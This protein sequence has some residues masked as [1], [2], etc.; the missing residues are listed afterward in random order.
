MAAE[1]T[2]LMQQ[3]REVK[4]RHPDA[5]VF[6]R[7]G[8]FYEL[9][10]EDAEEGARLLG[11][12]L[13]SRNN[14][15]SRAPLAGVPAQALDT[16][17]Q[18][19]VK[20]GRRVSICDQVEDPALAKGIIRREVTQTVTPGAV[21]ADALLDARRNNFLVALAGSPE[22]DALVG[23][24]ISDLSTGEL[25]LLA[26]S[27]DALAEQLLQV[28]PS[29]LLLPRGWELLPPLYTGAAIRTYRS[30]WLFEPQTGAE[31]MKRAFG[32]LNLLGFGLQRED[33]ARVGA[34][35]ALLAYLAEIQ[36]SARNII[37]P[38]RLIGTGGA[39]AL[40]EMTRRNLELVEPLRGAGVEGTLLHVLDEAATPM[41]ARLLR[42]WLQ[43]PLLE[44]GEIHARQDAVAELDSDP[45]T[46]GALRAACGEIRDLERLGVKAAAGRA[47][48]REL[49]ALRLSLDRVPAVLLALDGV[50]AARLRD[51]RSGIDPMADLRTLLD[52][53]LD[54]E[55]PAVLA[56]GG[57]IRSGYDAELDE[58]RA[59]RD[60][61][62]DWIAQLQVRERERSGIASLKVGF[63][64]VFGYY[65][66]VTRS[67]L[68]RVPDDYM[69]KQTLSNAERYV[70]P[71]LKVWEERV[72]G[73]EEKIAAL[74]LQ[75]FAALRQQV[76]AE[77][78]RIH[79]LAERLAEVD[80]LAALAEVAGRRGYVR[81]EVHDGFGLEILGGRHP[82]VELMMAREEFIPNDVRLDGAARVM[83]LTGPNMAG[84]STV[85]RQVGLIVLMAQIG[86]FVP[87]RAASI[88]L[89]DRIFTRVGASDHLARGQSTF[90]VE[91]NETAAILHG[92]NARS[93][94]LLD[95]IGRG[96]S[97]WDGL[98]V[99]TA[100]TEHLHEETGSKTIFAT[101]Y[102]ELTQLAERLDGVVNFSVAVREDA[103]Q[104]VF[105]RRLVA[106]GAD[107]SYGVEVARLAGLP[108]PVIGRARQLLHELEQG[109][110]VTAAPAA[111]AAASAQL[112]LFEPPPHPALERL[113]AL[114]IDDLTPRQALNV[115]ADLAALA[116]S[117]RS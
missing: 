83:I 32:V 57:V 26:L 67:N 16:Y 15:S 73:A 3:W 27:W 90:M 45:A 6:F 21:F 48:P 86:A 53:A 101:H 9:F 43:T 93:L 60:G 104:I 68:E 82:V 59:A 65:L 94:V 87:A 70:T 22:S 5:L 111:A 24:A 33:D 74:E 103:N 1:D 69:R 72:L 36:P 29:E 66:E 95:E 31:E 112:A 2:P 116:A 108:A 38:P 11:L 114:D 49:Q 97:T 77:V 55:C 117:V 63:N 25:Q 56:E 20:L 113:R 92:A 7:V 102:H 13:T 19:L 8:D 110:G 34:C 41:G 89:V 79:R 51:H 18:R 44:L 58:L 23:M 78:P 88:G 100:V 10:N 62:V 61:A 115:L 106:G 14:G 37:R 46:R 50:K 99:A 76:A 52:A 4:A 42:R 98:S 81:P 105:L 109:R 28:E 40:D 80:V 96:T 47:A 35:G 107:R 54:P 71:E 12:T 91:M 64:R 30:D 75:L 39:M 84:K 17:L 85:L